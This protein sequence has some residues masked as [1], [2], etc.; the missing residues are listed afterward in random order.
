MNPNGPV[1]PW[2]TGE[3]EQN[4][5]LITV[6]TAVVGQHEQTIASVLSQHE[7]IA[8]QRRCADTAELLGAAQS[9][10][11]RVAVIGSDMRGFDRA[12][13][14]ALHIENVQVIAIN[15]P[16]D[17]YSMQRISALGI[18][19]A[20]RVEEIPEQL[21]QLIQAVTFPGTDNS[22]A[23][24]H[25]THAAQIP[26]TQTEIP[27]P[28][29]FPDNDLSFVDSLT[30]ER[31]MSRSLIAQLRA[32]IAQSEEQLFD[33]VLTAGNKPVEIG[34]DSFRPPDGE[35]L[36]AIGTS[37]DLWGAEDMLLPELEASSDIISV[38]QMKEI[39]EALA[40]TGNELND[41]F[42]T[43]SGVQEAPIEGTQTG[44]TSAFSETLLD[45]EGV[46]E[47]TFSRKSAYTHGGNSDSETG[48]IVVVWSPHG[49]PGRSTVAAALAFALSQSTQTSESEDATRR[50][51]LRKKPLGGGA[52]AQE[53][54][55][56]NL[57][58]LLLDA[59][60]YAPSQAQALGLL[61]ESSGLAQACRQANQG[62]MS[63]DS[64]AGAV[65]AVSPDVHLL[66][67]IPRPERWTELSP[68]AL[69]AVMEQARKDYA[70]SVV[71]CAP[72]TEFDEI[73]SYESRAPQRNSATRTA[74][75][76]ADL[77]VIVGKS[78]P[79]SVKRLVGAVNDY[80]EGPASH[81][82]SIVVVNQS[83]TRISGKNRRAQVSKALKRFAN[84]ND[85][86]FVA[87]EPDAVV[88]ALELGRT[89]T[90][91]RNKS[92]FSA[93][94]RTLAHVVTA[95]F[96]EAQRGGPSNS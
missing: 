69:Q 74:L 26:D 10:A 62:L 49:A 2:G 48:K 76:N 23:A 79:V 40:S 5:S 3:R 27:T 65:Q 9:G 50:S 83:P 66:T 22:L 91:S 21:P 63:S 1:S 60:T 4:R 6:I 17:Q 87:Y 32:S 13:I 81:T 54:T 95:G 16:I 12:L 82:P 14:E 18:T 94:V 33:Q 19:H 92:E 28:R 78:D 30:S 31:T 80:A 75:E 68:H 37:V 57:P 93:S 46:V 29:E 72:P 43:Y 52:S 38:A 42:H 89:T 44:D 58:V 51:W 53:S 25:G 20:L 7:R 41:D 45:F 73:L 77:V 56:G 55:L 61:D 67:G 90:E 70:W 86:F 64:L 84:V 71:D 47:H 59:D 36:D 96:V 11:G 88:G 35:L 15:D 85:P 34:N 39:V 8:I 24:H